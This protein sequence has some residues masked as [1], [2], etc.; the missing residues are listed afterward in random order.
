M[1]YLV[2]RGVYSADGIGFVVWRLFWHKEPVSHSDKVHDLFS[3]QEC[4]CSTDG[5]GFVEIC[6]IYSIQGS[7]SMVWY[8]LKEN[9]TTY[10][11]NPSEVWALYTYVFTIHTYC[12]CIP[13]CH[14]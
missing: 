14:I 2:I 4:L 8:C 12:T 3:D 13:V 1:I 7:L 5:M 11:K 9:D 6:G 10:L